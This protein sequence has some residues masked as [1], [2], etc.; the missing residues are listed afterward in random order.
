M[1]P[2]S[3]T[4][5]VGWAVSPIIKRMLSVVQ[6]YISS[7][8]RWESDMISDLKNLE[9]TLMEILLVVGAAE[10]RNPNDK[11]QVIL[12]RQMKQA[13]YDAEDLLDKFDYKI[14]REEIEH[15]SMVRHIASS[16]ISIAKRLIGRDKLRSK[17]RKVIE[18]MA[19]VRS[20]AE[21]FVRVM[22]VESTDS[23]RSVERVPERATG[24]LLHEGATFGREKEVDELF[25]W[26]LSQNDVSSPGNGVSI[27]VYTV[28]GVGG[29][30]KTTIAQL[31]YNDK[32]IAD[33]FDTR[34]WVCVSHNFN[35]INL[36]KEIIA[37]IAGGKNIEL[38]NF[39][40]SMLQEELRRRILDRRFFLVLDDVWYDEK[41]GEHINKERWREVVVPME[42]ALPGSKILVTARMELVAK[43][44]NSRNSLF[45]QGLG[46]D[47]S[48]S[49]LRNLAFRPKCLNPDL[50][51][52]GRE[53]ARVLN[54]LPLAL[55]VIGGLLNGKDRVAE[56]TEVLQNNILKSI[57]ILTILHLS[58]ECL[59]EHLQHCFAYCSLFPKGYHI[60]P[61]RVIHMWIAQ[62]FVDIKESTYST[63]QD[64]GRSYFND[65]LSRSFFQFI[66]CGD[67]TFYVMHDIMSDLAL[68]VSEGECLRLECK[69]MK[70]MPIYTRHLSISIENLGNLVDYDL[71]TLRSLIVLS[72]SWFC[73]KVCLNHD[74]LGKLKSVRVLDI[75]GC[76]LE[77]LPDT[78]NQLIHLRYIGI[79]RTYYPL[80]KS[81]S[82]YHLQSLFVQ[83][84]SCYSLREYG[85]SSRGE[86]KTVG[87]NFHLPGSINKLTNL[88]HV[89][90]EKAYVLMLSR[91]CNLPSI[92]C[93][94]E[95]HVDKEEGSL[96]GLKNLNMLRGQLTIMCLDRVKGRDKA[97][98]CH[99]HLKEHIT[100]LELQWESRECQ[101]DLKD[102]HIWDRRFYRRRLR[103]RFNTLPTRTQIADGYVNDCSFEVLDVLKP[104]RDLEELTI[105]GYPGPRPPSWLEAN[106]LIRVQS[107][108]LRDCDGLEVLPSLGDLPRLKTLE[109][110][111]MKALKRIGQEFLG[112]AG[113]PSLER[114]VLEHLPGMEWCVV[115][116]DR[117]F[118]NLKHLFIDGC[119]MFRSYPTYSRALEHFSLL[120]GL[121]EILLKILR[122][123]L[124][125]T[126]SFCYLLSSLFHVLH[127]H[128][129]EFVEN[130]EIYVDNVV[131]MSRTV[132]D[133]MKSLQRLKISG[134]I[135]GAN[136]FLVIT[137]LWDE[138]GFTVIPSSLRHLEL[139]WC[140][141]QLSS[142]YK[143]LDNR[144]S[145][146]SVCLSGCDTIEMPSPPISLRHLRTLKKL[147]I[148][149]C[150]WITTFEES[151]AL[152]SLENVSIMH[153]CNLIHV[154]DL[155]DMPTLQKLYL[156]HCPQLVRLPKGGH[157]TTLKE[158]VIEHCNA[159]S[160]L[161]ELH[162]LVSLIK[163]RVSDCS[164]LVLLPNMDAFYSLRILIILRCPQ[165]RSLPR[166][167][168]PVS[169]EAF[170]LYHC[171]QELEEQFQQKKGPDWNKVVAHSGC[172]NCT[173][174]DYE[175][176]GTEREIWDKF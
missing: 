20:C 21:M 131:G 148:S 99:L 136:T 49:L 71:T 36:M 3:T 78:V 158:L 156:R 151:E 169:L 96:I 74:I 65:L 123:N 35:K 134:I 108:C 47:A 172:M 62:G 124:D 14:I 54:G 34:M 163:L 112:C 138:A 70:E 125:S 1:A 94:G 88:V 115:D 15:Q 89:S 12:L 7:Q 26:I 80:P 10:R 142:F 59:P 104:H 38:T 86:A 113:F 166:N 176:R 67:Q 161:A 152:I 165:L 129:L 81:M 51:S 146:V 150:D 159:L 103:R 162:G 17:L 143:L 2:I 33:T 167:G 101:R 147:E 23:I 48:W 137:T 93:A 75:S 90:V 53:I 92:E 63:L 175:K 114:L 40:F 28:V 30:G 69:S 25:S 55:K 153:C 84:H 77:R 79:R 37:H 16:S 42:N 133:M 83:Y 6:S 61:I 76:C 95:F 9:A 11:N 160:S 18:S 39:N 5:V 154:L 110:R 58:Y 57:D 117:V 50:E 82:L 91:A 46:Q 8:Y 135:N 27:D 72:K 119:P 106:W 60:D 29:I 56:W 64:A 126:R 107:I 130:L 97:S 109:I 31:V 118:L 22:A 141:L 155:S 66:R 121:G 164:K 111:R 168:L 45:L 24:S 87:C 43:I 102:A 140:N 139:D 100:K 174:P 73:S 128:H 41:F 85:N 171:H 4:A 127:P 52:I 105:S 68:H 32:R 98:N 122:Y 19:R 44:L 144:P 149:S 13:V 173:G 132:F 120:L 145:I 170:M 116:N 157:Q